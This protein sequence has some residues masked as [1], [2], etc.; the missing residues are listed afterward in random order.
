MIVVSDTSA[1]TALLTVGKSNL[2]QELFSSVSIP[3]A[4]YVELLRQHPSLPEWIH[5]EGVQHLEMVQFYLDRID[6]GEAE[7]IQLAREIKADRLLIDD[8]KGRTVALREGI[9][10]IG[11]LGVVILARKQEL[12]PS[13]RFAPKIGCRSGRLSS[14]R[15]G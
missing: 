13:A 8:Q 14:R 9:P 11:L 4:V 1:V 15:F 10:I 6:R 12:I 2:L 5:V 3:T 7:A